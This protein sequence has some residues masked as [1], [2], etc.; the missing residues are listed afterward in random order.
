MLA[1][2]VQSPEP[3]G[4]PTAESTKSFW[5]T[6]PSTLLMGHRSTRNLPP[7]ADV[8]IIGSGITGASVAHHFLNDDSHGGS[9]RGGATGKGPSV[10]MLEAREA[11]WGATGRNGG[12]C[13]PL[14]LEHARDASIARFELD[15]FHTLSSLI[16][17][18]KIQCE[19]V[20]Q[21]SVRGIYS[22]RHLAETETAL[23]VIQSTDPDLRQM[24]KM[25]EKPSELKEL[26]LRPG[27]GMKG[28]GGAIAAIVTNTAARLWPYKF[29]ARILEDLLLSTAPPSTGSFNLQTLTPV[30][31]LA[32]TADEQWSVSTA[33][34][35]ITARKV[36]LATN[37][38]TSHLLPS[39][40]DL[41]VPCRGQMSALLPDSSFHDVNRLQ[42]SYGLVGEGLDDYLIQR[43]N[44]TSGHLMFGGGRQMGPSL[45]ITDDSVIDANTATYLRSKLLDVFIASSAMESKSISN[46]ADTAKLE[47]SATNE[48]TGI[49]GYSRDDVPWVG[50]VPA[51]LISSSEP[52]ASHGSAP[53]TNLF[54]AAGYTGHGMPNGW[55]CG[56]AVALMAADDGNHDAGRIEVARKEVRLP[57]AYLVTEERVQR[58]RAMASVAAKD[59]AEIPRGG[60]TREIA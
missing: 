32:R 46:A 56:K 12:H 37:A 49:M 18:K 48:W 57:Q 16:E 36:I 10:V 44:E 8:V 3:A 14:L 26:R 60:V 38:Y 4:L 59:W 30:Q 7:T 2:S 42:N 41:I 53:S 40:S 31:A 17:N 20:P 39:F 43:P 51:S 9:T 55:L 28:D 24:M 23:A 22:S 45:H 52:S 5:H 1:M 54:V 58:V 11:C 35:N 13:Q 19:F 15:N 25:V 47:L 33:R 29:V 21:H 50:P 6:Q 27:T 34:G